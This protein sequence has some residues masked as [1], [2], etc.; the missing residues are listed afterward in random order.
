MGP[1]SIYTIYYSAR[2][3]ITSYNTDILL[4]IVNWFN[5]ILAIAIQQDND[6]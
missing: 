1:K 5:T 3:Y 6:Q 2:K 4:L